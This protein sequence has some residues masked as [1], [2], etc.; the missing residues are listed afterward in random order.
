MLAGGVVADGTKLDEAASAVAPQR[1]VRPVQG[2]SSAQLLPERLEDVATLG[3]REV[4]DTRADDAGNAGAEELRAQV[5]DAHVPAAI[6]DD[7][8]RAERRSPKERLA[9]FADGSVRLGSVSV[10]AESDDATRRFVR[11]PGRP[12]ECAA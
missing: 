7:D 1:L 5:V 9:P 4:V 6:V 2:S 8:E 12:L 10:P 11:R 3:R